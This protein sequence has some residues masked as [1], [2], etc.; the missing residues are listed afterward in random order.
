MLQTKYIFFYMSKPAQYLFPASPLLR[1]LWPLVLG[2]ASCAPNHKQQLPLK[3]V[4]V[5]E[6]SF[7]HPIDNL[8][9]TAKQPP[10]EDSLQ[11]ELTSQAHI[12]LGYHHT[13]RSGI[14]LSLVAFDTRDFNLRVA[15][16]LNGP[17]T[18]WVNAEDTAKSH[19][20]VAAINGGFFTPE[21]K[22]LGLL[23]TDGRQRGHL[24]RSSLGSGIYFATAHETALVRREFYLKNK[25]SWGKAQQLLQTGPMLAENGASI[26]G[27]SKQNNR[28]RC[29]LAWDG[30]NHWAIGYAEACSLDALSRAIAGRA[31]AGFKIQHAVNLDGGRSSDFWIGPKVSNGNHHHRSFLRK[32]ARNYLVLTP[33]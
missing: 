3:G 27:L 19:R 1:V 13:S 8:D 7:D 23:T 29:F 18:H 21:G 26:A 16:Q 32:P 30:K 9:S 22:P 24:N 2:L 33:K 6:T 14:T 10:S 5:A 25:S 20:G 15:D 28:P 11:P 12:Q 4:Q 31:P 17:A